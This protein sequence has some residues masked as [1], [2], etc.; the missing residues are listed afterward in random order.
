MLDADN[1][2]EDLDLLKETCWLEN[3]FLCSFEFFSSTD[4]A[5]R[6]AP[7]EKH[8]KCSLCS[9]A[10]GTKRGLNIHRAKAHRKPQL[11]HTRL[12]ARDLLDALNFEELRQQFCFELGR[13]ADLRKQQTVLPEP[14]EAFV[15][16]AFKHAPSDSLMGNLNAEQSLESVPNANASANNPRASL[17][18]SSNVN[19]TIVSNAV[20]ETIV[21]SDPG[22][23]NLPQ[24]ALQASTADP[25]L[26]EVEVDMENDPDPHLS[27]LFEEKGSPSRYSEQCAHDHKQAPECTHAGWHCFIGYRNTLT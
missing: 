13:P 24:V 10:A 14:T 5:T 25:V 12:S 20:N 6:P 27:Y 1:A 3:S 21:S 22:S 4:C 23:A 2:Y 16:S 19:E 7:Q 15:S 9:F 17:Q 11:P 26:F 8:E 18:S